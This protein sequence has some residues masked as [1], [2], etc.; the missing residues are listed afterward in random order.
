[1][2]FYWRRWTPSVILT[3][4]LISIRRISS[5][6][7]DCCK[8]NLACRTPGLRALSQSRQHDAKN[9]TRRANCARADKEHSVGIHQRMAMMREIFDQ[10]SGRT[11]QDFSKPYVSR[12]QERVLRRCIADA[13]QARHVSDQG[14]AGKGPSKIVRRQD[15]AEGDDVRTMKSHNGVGSYPDCLDGSP[16]DQRLEIAESD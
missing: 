5:T 12:R 15:R 8:R 14:H 3:R 4:S 9:Q 2:I 6:E 13:G 16:C 10:N 7:F 11:F 1:R